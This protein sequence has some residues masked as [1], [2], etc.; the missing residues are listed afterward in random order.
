MTRRPVPGRETLAGDNEGSGVGS[1]VKEEL[2]EDVDSQ[3]AVGGDVVVGKTHDD[4]EDSQDSEAG[5]LKGLATNGIDC[6]HREPVSRH[7]T[8]EN[9]DQVADGGVV[10]VFVCRCRSSGGVADDIED[11]GVVEGETIV[12]N[13]EKAPGEGRS[14]QM[15]G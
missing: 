1:E 15:S 14:V 4:E 12:G 13:V 2:S 6:G 10:E 8:G 11:G 9:N 5:K 7:G 3:Q